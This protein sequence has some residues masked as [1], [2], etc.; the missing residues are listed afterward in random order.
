MSERT[1]VQVGIVCPACNRPGVV[2]LPK[3]GLD[4]WKN[5]RMS[6]Q[7]A[8]PDLTATTRERLLTGYCPA[9]QEEIFGTDD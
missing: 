2:F 3:E 9:C 7:K 5:K 4:N 8:F 1:M 6:V